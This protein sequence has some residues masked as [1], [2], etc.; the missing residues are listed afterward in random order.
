MEREEIIKHF[1]LT[2]NISYELW[3]SNK[4]IGEAL[5]KSHFDCDIFWGLSIGNIEGVL[6]KTERKE[7]YNGKMITV[8]YYL[9]RDQIQD[10]QITFI[11][12]NR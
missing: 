8:P 2:L 12:R 6:I 1:P 10:K 7:N 5:L 4:N 3:D 9:Q 11:L